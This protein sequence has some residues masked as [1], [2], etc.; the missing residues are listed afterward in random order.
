M[1]EHRLGGQ[2]ARSIPD[3]EPF[4]QV[5]GFLRDDTPF[6]IG[7][8]VTALLNARKQEIL[9]RLTSLAL[10]PSA[11]GA[12]VAVERRVTAQQNVHDDT[13]RPKIAPLVVA[14]GVP[15]ER[16]HYFG[17][18]K[19]S[20]AYRSQELRGGNGRVEGRIEFD[21]RAEIKIADLDRCQAV[22]IDAEDVFRFQVP[23]SNA[24]LVQELQAARQIAYHQTRLMFRK[25]HTPLDV[26][27]Q[28]T[29]DNLL[30]NQVEA[31]LFLE[32]LNQLDYVRVA[33]AVVERLNFLKYTVA[34][35]AGNFLDDLITT[36]T[37]KND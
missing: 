25:V 28:R 22:R 17:S 11:A 12:A 4:N 19:L 34:A 23:V 8:L 26:R 31:I 29:A 15:Y 13:E 2:A 9:T 7:E 10:L 14:S 32:E 3:E 1:L 35:V 33:L 30:E 16:V 36:T 24:F 6:P 18:H 27:Q 5:L 21:A 37:T 20:T